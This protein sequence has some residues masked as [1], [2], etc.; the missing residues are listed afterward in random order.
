MAYLLGM[1][2]RWWILQI[3][4]VLNVFFFGWLA[5]LLIYRF[6]YTTTESRLLLVGILWSAGTLISVSRALTDLPALCLSVW[7]MTRM[8]PRDHHHSSTIAAMG[9]TA[10][11]ALIKETAILS[12]FGLWRIEN[13][14][15]LL[16]SLFSLPIIALPVA[17]WFL[18][19]R[20]VVGPDKAGVGNF[21]YPFFGF[22]E[23]LRLEWSEAILEFPRLPILEMIA[24]LSMAIQVIWLVRC[25]AWRSEWWR[26]GAPYILLTIAIGDYVW[27]SQSAYSRC[28]LPMTVCFNVLLYQ[29]DLSKKANRWW[30][31]LGNLG[32]LDRA[33]IGL[34]LMGIV[35]WGMRFTRG[36][37]IAKAPLLK[38]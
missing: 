15:A 4:S 35:G 23:K 38:P 9:L 6:G 12:V 10:S 8:Y 20:S 16:C 30:W 32:L 7:A 26:W 19:A 18:Y 25:F 36:N 5:W 17:G 33:A 31:L 3:Y 21:S 2:Q 34:L 22:F 11:A 37:E 24:P 27:A 29:N 1:G 13:R 28:L 14:R